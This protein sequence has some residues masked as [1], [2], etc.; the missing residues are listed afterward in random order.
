MLYGWSQGQL[1]RWKY[2]S[3][4]WW[5]QSYW[6]MLLI[7]CR[8]I[9]WRKKHHDLS[10]TPLSIAMNT[11]MLRLGSYDPSQSVIPDI[12]DCCA[13]GTQFYGSQLHCLWH[14][15]MFEF[16]ILFHWLVHA[17]DENSNVINE[18]NWFPLQYGKKSF[19]AVL[20]ASSNSSHA[21]RQ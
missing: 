14:T 13:V 17:L 8:D 15:V 20:S 18:L 11:V 21:H 10:C 4:D 3:F 5:W 9:F 2:I 6:A 7:F 12:Q 19:I 16:W 1:H